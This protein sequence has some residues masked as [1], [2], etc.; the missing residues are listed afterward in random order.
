[1]FSLLYTFTCR[2]IMEN[3]NLVLSCIFLKCSVYIFV[4]YCSNC[5]VAIFTFL[6]LYTNYYESIAEIYNKGKE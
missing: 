1:M 5:E 4:P 3:N 2:L 6:V